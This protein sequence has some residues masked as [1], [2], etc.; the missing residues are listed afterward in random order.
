MNSS[1][2]QKKKLK[3]VAISPPIVLPSPS[4]QKPKQIKKG[5]KK[6]NAENDASKSNI[7]KKK[8]IAEVPNVKPSC[9]L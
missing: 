8:C 2:I 6:K 9:N 5:M 7:P 3:A 1:P 4:K